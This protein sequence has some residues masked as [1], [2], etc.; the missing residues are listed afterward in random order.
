MADSN[1]EGELQAIKT[2]AEALQQLDPVARER[3]LQ[4]AMQHLGLDVGAVRPDAERRS[5]TPPADGSPKAAPESRSAQQLRDIRSFKEQKQPQSDIQ[6]AVLAAYYLSEL[7]PEGSRKPTIAKSDMTEL[8]I[9]AGYPLPTRTDFTLSN[10]KQ[11][12]YL[13]SAGHG[14]YKLNPVGHNLVAHSLPKSGSDAKTPRRRRKKKTLGKK[15]VKKA[16]SK[17]KKTGRKAK[18]KK[19]GKK[20]R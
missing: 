15:A 3:A 7:A 8:F 17:K 18:S 19:K 5:A 11:A 20:T 13:D 10:A 16:T 1:I 2:I 6:M 14:K 9:Q 4:Y 12:G